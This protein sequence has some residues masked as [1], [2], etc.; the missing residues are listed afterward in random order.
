MVKKMSNKWGKF[1]QRTLA[2]IVIGYSLVAWI[3]IQLIEAVLPTFEAPLWVAQTLTFLLILGFPLALVAGWLI[4]KIYAGSEFNENDTQTETSTLARKISYKKLFGVGIGVFSVVGLFGF[5]MVP[6]IFD[7]DSP[8]NLQPRK[9]ERQ[10][11][12][13]FSQLDDRARGVRSLINLGYTSLNDWGLRTEIA[14]SSNGRYLAYT[15]NKE[16]ES[17]IFA[18]DLWYENSV[19]KL[20]D[21]SWSTDV[22]GVIFFDEDGEWLYFFDAGILKRVRV[23]GG[24]VQVII[25]EQ[26]NMTSGYFA[27]EDSVI[28]TG[29]ENMLH[30]ISINERTTKQLTFF[31]AEETKIYRWPYLLPDNKNILMTAAKLGATFEGDTLIYD[32]ETNEHSTL[33]YGAYNARYIKTGHIVFMRDSSLWAVPFD[34]ETQKIIGNE[35]V[36]IVGIHS[37]GQVGAASYSFSDNGTLV[38]LK[39]SDTYAGAEAT[40]ISWI[41][42]TGISEPLNIQNSGRLSQVRV[43]PSGTKIAFSV[44]DTTSSSDIWIWDEDR[45][46]SRRITFSGLA[47]YPIWSSK[48]DYIVY[49]NGG[50]F[51]SSE[52]NSGLWVISADGTGQP[53]QALSGENLYNPVSIS[54]DDKELLVFSP[55]SDSRGLYRYPLSNDFIV[56]GAA[57]KVEISAFDGLNNYHGTAISPDEKWLAYVSYETGVAQI[58]V[59]PY[60][61]VESGKW[62]IS[63][64][65]ALSPL[66]GDNGKSLFFWSGSEQYQVEYTV[67]PERADGSSGFIDLGQPELMF[68]VSGLQNGLTLPAW[69]Y[70]AQLDKFAMLETGSSE[71]N[72]ESEDEFGSAQTELYIVEGWFNEITNLVPKR[73]D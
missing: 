44:F 54:L 56:D 34:L 49:Q 4:E 9:N 60:P 10:E 36:V 51:R 48:G 46:T 31:D 14:L 6:F 7:K 1:K 19:S 68:S 71:K 24:S 27:T 20:A 25:D 40:N 11:N 70:S 62:Q 5:Y 72:T 52:E 3:L 17:E 55:E 65:N 37:Q 30:R 58:Y 8:I 13:L 69:D 33:L 45:K 73:L 42:R 63:Y 38:Y 28:Y 29:A 15:S 66:W 22:H 47:Q 35:E 39:G 67:G 21:Y 18:K 16:G 32:L 50:S 23:E 2:R 26:L 59:R 57:T 53:I 12:S 43:S 64:P 41:N 61:D